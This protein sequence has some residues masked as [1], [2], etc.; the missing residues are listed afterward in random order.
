MGFTPGGSAGQQ[1]GG[2]QP[3]QSSDFLMATKPVLSD[4]SNVSNFA[5]APTP[6]P[7]TT[8]PASTVSST[9]AYVVTAPPA[10]AAAPVFKPTAPAA[11]ATPAYTASYDTAKYHNPYTVGSSMWQNTEDFLN[12]NYGKYGTGK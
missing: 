2:G 3:Q 10:A 12:K 5:N 1:G 11:P 6:A 9:P 8:A 4:I 7:V